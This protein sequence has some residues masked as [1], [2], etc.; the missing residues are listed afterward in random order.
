MA[1]EE[2]TKSGVLVAD[3]M[4]H[5]ATLVGQMLRALGRK[6]IREAYD[7]TRAMAELKRRIFD[8]LIIDADLDGMDGVSFTRKLRAA[9][10]CQNRDIAIIMMSSAPDAKRIAAA[11]D[12]GVTEFLRKPFAAS[13]LQSRLTNLQANPRG[14]IETE[15]YKGPDRRRKVL[16]V[17]AERRGGKG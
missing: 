16:D 11:R 15:A 17:G 5:M 14:F 13:H 8:V 6:D 10:D 12:A 7:A 1:T 9:S 3:S 2:I 4:P